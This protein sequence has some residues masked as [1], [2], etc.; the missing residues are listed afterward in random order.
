MRVEVAVA[1]ARCH[2]GVVDLHRSRTRKRESMTQVSI[3]SLTL[4]KS[5]GPKDIP[6][7]P[8]KQPA[9]IAKNEAE[10]PGYKKSGYSHCFQVD[11]ECGEPNNRLL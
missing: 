4:T 7:P 1:T 11:V 10:L 5:N 2:L 3:S 8:T 6:K 9:M